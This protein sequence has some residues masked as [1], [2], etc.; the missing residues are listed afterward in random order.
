M[1]KRTAVT[2]ELIAAYRATD[3][4]AVGAG[5]RLTLRIGEKSTQADGLFQQMGVQG[6]AFLTAYNPYSVDVGAA[7]NEARQQRLRADLDAL[8][9]L[10]IWEGYGLGRDGEWPAEPS[11]LIWGIGRAAATELAVRYEQNA[12][13][14]MERGEAALLVFPFS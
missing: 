12:F 1:I 6:A 11:L 2:P 10:T 4:V 5:V 13:V 9:G 7:E 8:E 3:Y 14:W